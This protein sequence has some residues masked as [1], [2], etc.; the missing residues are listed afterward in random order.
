[1]TLENKNKLEKQLVLHEGLKLKPYTCTAGKLT[2]GIGRNL[3]DVGISERE[4]Y[5]LL[6]TDVEEARKGCQNLI[7]GFNAINDTRQIALIDMMFNLG[8]TRMSKFCKMLAA[9]K[10]GD[11]EAAAEQAKESRWYNQVGNRAKTIVRQLKE[12]EL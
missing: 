6:Q 3:D 8:Y 10:C 7:T 4:A 9:I 11:W 2:I 5:I 12:G 1:M